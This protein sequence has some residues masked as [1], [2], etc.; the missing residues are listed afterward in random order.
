MR[1]VYVEGV[2]ISVCLLMSALLSSDVHV[3][4]VLLP[5]VVAARHVADLVLQLAV[6]QISISI[7]ILKGWESKIFET[8]FAKLSQIQEKDLT[9]IDNSVKI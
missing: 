7:C 6:L 8:F 5:G 2:S 3:D 9:I 4:G 1:D